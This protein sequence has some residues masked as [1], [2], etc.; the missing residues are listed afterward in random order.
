MSDVN[1]DSRG[2]SDSQSFSA[3][4]DAICDR[5][6]A[7]WK[8][9]QG[10]KIEDYLLPQ[11][12]TAARRQLLVELV[13]LDLGYRWQRASDRDAAT[14]EHDATPADEPSRL[15]WKPR[16]EEYLAG[17]PEL[18]PPAEL[19]VSLIATEYRTR[20][21]AGDRPQREDYLARF[22]EQRDEL[23]GLFAR[24]D[25]EGTKE[26]QPAEPGW[27]LGTRV[28]Y[29]GDYELLEEIARGGMG[30]VYKARQRSLNRIVAL[31]MIL[32]G[33]LAGEQDVQ[34]FHAE[35]EAAAILDHPGIVPIYEVGEHE[36]QHFFSM[37]YVEGES[38]AKRLANGPLAAKDAAELM[39]AVAEAVAYAHGKGVIHRDLKPANILLDCQGRP[40]ITDFG[41][42]KRVSGEAGL[43]ATGQVLGTP[44]YMPSEQALGSLDQIKETADVYSLGATLYALL[45]GRPPFQAAN[46]M[47]TLLQ[48]ISA[49][50]VSLRQLNAKLARD[51]ETICQKCLEKE[52]RRR[53]ATAKELADEL[54]RYLDG[55]P[56]H[57]RPVGRPER[58]W[59]WCKRQPVVA[60]LAAAIVLS[61]LVGTGV[62]SY[63]AITARRKADEAE[64]A[65]G[66]AVAAQRE[67]DVQRQA[68]EKN[69]RAAKRQLALS[70]I[71]RGVNELEHGNHHRGLAILGQARSCARDGGDKQLQQVGRAL[72]AGWATACEIRL[73][74]EDLV[75]GL[76]FSPDGTRI[77][78]ASFD[79][80][81]RVWDASTGSPLGVPMRHRHGVLSVAFSPNGARIATA[82]SDRTARL[83]DAATGK[84][85]SGPMTHNGEVSCVAFSPDGGRIAT[86]SD[87]GTARLWDAA[88]GKPLGVPMTHGAQVNSVAFSPDGTRI[89]TASFDGTARVWDASTGSPLGVPMRHPSQVWSLAFSPDG[90]RL[91]TRC[92]DHAARLWDVATGRPVGEPMKH[93]AEV[94]TVVF[95][96]DGTWIATASNDGTA[97]L[98]DAV[99]G[100]PLGVPMVH[101]NLVWSATF[102]PDGTRIATGSFDGTARVWEAAPGE[103]LRVT[104][105]H[106]GAIRFMAFS[107]D[108]TRIATA[109]YDRTARVWD[110][111]AGEPPSLPIRHLAQV[112]SVAFSPDGTRIATASQD[113]TARVWDAAT[114]KPL[115]MPMPHDGKVSSVAFSPDGT[116]I[117]TASKDKT[118]RLWDA[119]TGK[120]LG[121]P[122]MHDDEVRSA[123]FSPDGARIA[124]A[125]FDG[126]ARL[127]DAATGSPLGLP[128][129]HHGRVFSVVFSPDGA[130]V[131]TGSMENKARLWDAATGKPLGEPMTHHDSVSA[132]AFSPD[133]TRI[134]TGSGDGTVRLWDAATGKPLCEPMK[135]GAAVQ[136]VAF[137]PDGTRLA[138]RCYDY[139]ARLWD[140]ATGRPVGEPMTHNGLVTSVAFSPDG[141]RIAT[142]SNDHTARLWDA[143]TGKPLGVPMVHGD[144]LSSAIFSP[145][146]TRIATAS[147]DKTARLWA[148][149]LTLPDDPRWIDAFVRFRSHFDA[150][151]EGNLHPITD[152]ELAE[153]THVVLASPA[154][155]EQLASTRSRQVRASHA[156]EADENESQCRWFAA[157]FHLRQLCELEPQNA[158][159]RQRLAKAMEHLKQASAQAVKK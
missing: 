124:T 139:A 3:E 56:I 79:G 18:G 99:S 4:I 31:K 144:S 48:V 29:F 90:T 20:L 126:T 119:A 42:A 28:K 82:S 1:P 44:S 151:S 38:L 147:D 78:T 83:W 64:A 94:S 6:E 77:A 136:R 129:K 149:P 118:A 10:P 130:R 121:A 92:Y 40:R 132:V 39:V 98:W 96:P 88:A 109:S 153:A 158:E 76:A 91:A 49:E 70:Y 97:R 114:S 131:V 11:T 8:A 108:G 55:E 32:A 152:E 74:H 85:L 72:L 27:Q 81:A 116:R 111:A 95:S 146:G 24:M 59:R 2:A 125:S 127:W 106:D 134:A 135:H 69:W 54:R 5:F 22:P 80:T 66:A 138:T 21:L 100:K 120:P 15:S 86:A 157:A 84:A 107:P 9:G 110:S 37:G 60:G 61:L 154:Y 26:P 16:L 58:L 46:P 102:S 155:L 57:A 68:A 7:A 12:N 112:V 137:G 101:E 33:Q 14:I 87:D 105:K 43:T 89:A 62:S 23:N 103:L 30:V 117:A 123:T 150:N 143:A 142:A 159:W 34:R 13:K 53:Y 17:Y 25:N 47:D 122:M 36:G 65:R 133:G 104:G 41:L 50:P 52:P 63:F 35:A 140:V 113:N 141:T 67:T 93:G 51:L 148:V 45:T 115:G 156:V 71:D 128:M 145:D 19:P 75:E 73:Q